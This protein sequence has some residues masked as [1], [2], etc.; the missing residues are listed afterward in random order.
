MNNYL[1]FL[2]A[3]KYDLFSYNKAK[4]II[5]KAIICCDI[6]KINKTIK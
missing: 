6:F 2:R 5:Y 4:F 3:Y 1:V